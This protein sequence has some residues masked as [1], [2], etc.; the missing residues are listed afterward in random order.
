[1]LISSK[2]SRLT[3][4]QVVVVVFLFRHGRRSGALSLLAAPL[5]DKKKLF[6][7][8]EGGWRTTTLARRDLA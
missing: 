4:E 5:Q 3:L 1:M 6:R 2:A 7:W 8:P